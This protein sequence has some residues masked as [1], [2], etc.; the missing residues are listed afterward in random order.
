MSLSSVFDVKGADILKALTTILSEYDQMPDQPPDE[1]GRPKRSL[2]RKQTKRTGAGLGTS[3]AGSE[4]LEIEHGLAIGT[5]IPFSLDYFQTL[6]TF[7]DVLTEMYT[8]LRDLVNTIPML[9]SGMAYSV[10]P[11]SGYWIGMQTPNHNNNPLYSQLFPSDHVS[12]RNMPELP[13]PQSTSVTPVTANGSTS[14]AGAGTADTVLKLDGR[15]K[16]I[17]NQLLKELDAMA[18]DSIKDELSSLDPLLRNTTLSNPN[19]GTSGIFGLYALYS[20]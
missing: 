6:I 20:E 17:V 10:P 15:F 16:K 7:C 11:G 19:E 5:N 13:S 2:L 3:T 1:T 8:K 12:S 9:H 18:R 14:G 4:N